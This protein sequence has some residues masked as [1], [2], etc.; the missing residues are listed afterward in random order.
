MHLACSGAGPTTVLLLSGF[1]DDGGSW[2]AVTPAVAPEARICAPARFGTGSSDAPPTVQTFTSQAGDL[3]DALA[4]AGE[5]GPYV[6]VGHSFGGVEAVA[7]AS[8]FA[9]EVRGVLLID[10][11]PVDWPTVV[12]AVPDDGSVIA[13]GFRQ[14]CDSITDASHNRERLDGERAFAELAAIAEPG[15]LGGLPM[16]V[17]TR[18]EVRYDGLDA[19]AQASL[20]GAWQAGQARWAGMSSVGEVVEVPDTSHYVQVD[21]PEVVADRLLA[22]VS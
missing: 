14:T 11:S 3:H 8:R 4:A 5:P 1:E 6:V 12:C 17:L 22:L 13:A 2:G 20:A 21:Q 9:D 18:A 19:G 7:F 10:A 16:V 15:K